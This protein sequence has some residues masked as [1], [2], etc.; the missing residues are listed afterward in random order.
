MNSDVEF[1]EPRKAACDT[2]AK[3]ECEC[4]VTRT[5]IEPLSQKQGPLRRNWL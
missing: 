2:A 4:E 5:I 1:I 3:V